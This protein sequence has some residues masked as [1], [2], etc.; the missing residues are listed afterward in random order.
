MKAI[1][2]KKIGMT[3]VFSKEGE[4]IPV[5]AVSAGPC[6]VVQIKTLETDGYNSIQLGFG[7]KIK[8]PKKPIEGH[9]KKYNSE[10]MRVLREVRIENINDYSSGQQIKADIFK[11]G[12]RV[13]VVGTSKGKGFAGVVKRHNFSGGPATHGSRFHRAVGSIG[14]KKPA[15]TVK[16]RKMPGHMG[17][18]RVTVQGLSIQSVIPEKNLILIK[19]AVPGPKGGIILIKESIKH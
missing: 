15:R 18:R 10:P 3:Q 16:G 12:E 2:G 5:T 7:E 19:G 9:F 8:K 14:C 6:T 17:N 11:E 4:V 13:D 1:I